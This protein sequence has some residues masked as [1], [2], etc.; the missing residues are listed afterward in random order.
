MRSYEPQLLADW[1][2]QL[3]TLDVEGVAEQ[4]RN[5]MVA[6]ARREARSPAIRQD[7]TSPLFTFL[8]T[9]QLSTLT[10]QLVLLPLWI[11]PILYRDERCL[12]LVNGQTGKVVL[13]S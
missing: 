1:L 4:A 11:A 9:L 2:A 10:Y 7:K 5:A 6:L 12:V 13:C 8:S 3:Y